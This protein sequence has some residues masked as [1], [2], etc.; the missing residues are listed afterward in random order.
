MRISEFCRITGM[1]RQAIYWQI[2]NKKGYG[3]FFK[4]DIAGKWTIDKKCVQ[5]SELIELAS[6]MDKHKKLSVDIWEKAMKVLKIS[7]KSYKKICKAGKASQ[8]AQDQLCI[9]FE[10]YE[11]DKVSPNYSSTCWFN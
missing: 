8:D 11:L 6:M 9:E 1:S 4:K 5:S 10:D 7:S 3:L 2:K